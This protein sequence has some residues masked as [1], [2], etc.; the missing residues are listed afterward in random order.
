MDGSG[1]IQELN[2]L[3]SRMEV[4]F[5]V[6]DFGASDR[7][8]GII[9]LKEIGVKVNEGNNSQ[10]KPMEATVC[11]LL[12]EVPLVSWPV[13]EN[14]LL[15][16]ASEALHNKSHIS[17]C[18]RPFC[19]HCLRL[20]PACNEAGS[21]SAS[22]GWRRCGHCSASFCSEECEMRGTHTVLCGTHD[23]LRTFH[24]TYL[25]SL[26]KSSTTN[27]ND[28]AP[29]A[30]PLQHE[31]M[32]QEPIIS[33]PVSVEACARCI[34]VIA[35]RFIRVSK[36]NGMDLWAKPSN[37]TVDD[38]ALFGRTIDEFFLYATKPFNR[39]VEPPEGSEFE[40]VNIGAWCEA[41]QKIIREPLCAFL[42]GNKHHHNNN[43]RRDIPPPCWLERVLDGLLRNSTIITLIGQ[44]TINSQAI[45]LPIP[46]RVL[47][48]GGRHL[49]S[50]QSREEQS[51]LSDVHSEERKEILVG[52]AMF[53]IQS[54][55]N[56][57]CSPNV[58]VHT[59]EA[60]NHEISLVVTK[61]V[62]VGDEL[63]ITYIPTLYLALNSV[64]QRRERLASY[65]FVCQCPRC[66]EELKP[67]DCN[68]TH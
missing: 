61:H 57:S 11:S 5:A 27:H 8:K 47:I 22:V 6:K 31:A 18:L 56:H 52:G 7:G 59:T 24:F 54:C 53:S 34:A 25:Q 55:F 46:Q 66:M 32:Q 37:V 67:N 17:Q 68:I 42:L 23:A 50:D 62:M 58:E 35:Q 2:A 21:S 60:N 9:A 64:Q 49:N 29:D 4:P 28:T 63:T 30:E 43:N 14:L 26:V 20:S 1:D 38:N 19:D 36:S 15:A 12:E 40:Q 10:Q 13:P 3:L 16:R 39:L 41:I 48:E 33:V 44:L 65:F 51:S 45:V